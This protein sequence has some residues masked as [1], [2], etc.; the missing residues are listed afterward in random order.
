MPTMM[1]GLVNGII[2]R[3]FGNTVYLGIG[4]SF[5]LTGVLMMA[6]NAFVLTIPLEVTLI[7]REHNNGTLSASAYWT[8][9][10]A[11]ASTAAAL[12]AI[13]G[14]ATWWIVM[15]LPLHNLTALMTTTLA[16]M[17]ASATY[18]S[19]ATLVGILVPDAVAASQTCEPIVT[20]L[21]LTGG[22]MITAPQIKIYW[23]WLYYIN[24]CNYVTRVTMLEAFSNQNGNDHAKETLAY[25]HIHNGQSWTNIQYLAFIYLVSAVVGLRVAQVKFNR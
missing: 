25:F 19:F 15:G 10:L 4:L 16:L 3:N 24:P 9:R 12:I 7:M 21:Q 13:P 8:A 2:Y 14:T 11:L 20:L 5:A 18:G 1:S 17:I 22:V 6:F 23:K